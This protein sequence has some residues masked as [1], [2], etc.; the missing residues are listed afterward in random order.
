M[1]SEAEHLQKRI[2]RKLDY[3]ILPCL[4]LLWLVN[5]L[6]RSNVGN[7]RIVGLERDLNL[8]GNQFNVAVTAFFISDLPLDRSATLFLKRIKANRWIPVMVVAWGFVTIMTCFVHDFGGLVTARFCLGMCVEFKFCTAAVP[9]VQFR[10]N[11]FSRIGMFYAGASMGGAFGG[12]L[13]SAIVNMDGLGGLAGWRW[14]FILEGIATILIG[15]SMVYILPPDLM[16]AGFLT[17]EEKR[18]ASLRDIQTWL[19]GIATLALIVTLYSYALF[20]PTIITGLGY[21]GQQAQLRTVPPYVPAV[22]L[23]VLVAYWSDRLRLRIPF[24]LALLPLTIAGFVTAIL[25]HD[26]ETRY[27]AVFL[28]VA[29]AYPCTASVLTIIPNNTSGHYKRATSIGLLIA[30]ANCGGFISTFIFGLSKIVVLLRI[31]ELG[32]PAVALRCFWHLE[33]SEALEENATSEIDTS[34]VPCFSRASKA[35]TVKGTIYHT[36]TNLYLRKVELA[37]DSSAQTAILR[38]TA[39]VPA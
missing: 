36:L 1:H 21:S 11:D 19:T 6:D 16:S 15:V 12:L 34:I 8:R 20:L 5:Y 32:L 25:A 33:E 23:T 28:I 26:N 29:G 39:D 18:H 17:E 2:L 9:Q 10:T 27:A 22:F 38:S 14:I 35:P 7:A 3:H 31:H 24:A 30:L 13:A 4:T 37:K